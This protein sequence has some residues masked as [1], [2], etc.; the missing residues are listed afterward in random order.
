MSKVKITLK[1]D[2]K[3]AGYLFEMFRQ[4]VASGKSPLTKATLTQ[5]STPDESEIC[6]EVE[7]RI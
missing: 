6:I 5:I 2:R 3:L 7:S 4:E 1:G